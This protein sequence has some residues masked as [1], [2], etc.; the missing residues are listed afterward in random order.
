M[1]KEQRSLY[2]DQEAYT[3]NWKLN[4]ACDK[5]FI[6]SSSK[7][8][9]RCWEYWL[10]LLLSGKLNFP[11]EFHSYCKKTGMTAFLS[12]REMISSESQGPKT[13]HK[14]W[15]TGMNEPKTDVTSPGATFETSLSRETVTRKNE[16][17]PQDSLKKDQNQTNLC[18]PLPLEYQFDVTRS[19]NIISVPRAG[20][21]SQHGSTL[22]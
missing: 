12:N 3:N 7:I 6:M 19:N 21:R 17:T 11:V 8:F 16:N 22:K 18:V 14:E 13:K 4:W 9:P 5:I 10:H 1:L 20:A 2:S 15:K